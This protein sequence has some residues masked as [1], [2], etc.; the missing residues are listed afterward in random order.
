MLSKNT[1]NFKNNLSVWEFLSKFFFPTRINRSIYV[2]CSLHAAQFKGITHWFCVIQRMCNYVQYTT[3]AHSSIILFFS[4]Q[5]KKKMCR[6]GIYALVNVSYCSIHQC[7]R[8]NVLDLF[9]SFRTVAV[10]LLDQ[11]SNCKLW[12]FPSL[13]LWSTGQRIIRWAQLCPYICL[14]LKG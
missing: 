8:L 11:K 10:S 6:F 1:W 3:P 13:L 7:Y 5:R 4:D 9:V 12:F 14:H 2:G